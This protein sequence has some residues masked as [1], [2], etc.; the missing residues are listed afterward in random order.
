MY[1]QPGVME[2]MAKVERSIMSCKTL[3]QLDSARKMADNFK[4]AYHFHTLELTFIFPQLQKREK[5][6]L[7]NVMRRV[8]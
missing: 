3:T 1:N 8:K 4:T 7:R 2:A 6:L 5:Q